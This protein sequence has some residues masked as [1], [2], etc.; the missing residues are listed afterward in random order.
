MGEYYIR[1]F[2]LYKRDALLSFSEWEQSGVVGCSVVDGEEV[3]EEDGEEDG[4][5]CF[6]KL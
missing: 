5:V 4:R 2:L 1:L 3:G 6:K